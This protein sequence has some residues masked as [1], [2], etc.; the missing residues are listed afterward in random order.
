MKNSQLVKKILKFE[1]DLEIFFKSYE[2]TFEEYTGFEIDH[3]EYYNEE[4]AICLEESW[5][6]DPQCASI[7]IPLSEIDD[8]DSYLEKLV[9]E[10][11][12]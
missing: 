12:K 3:F 10:R 2:K 1:N 11:L 8:L 4:V 7:S 9:E 6:D 5:S